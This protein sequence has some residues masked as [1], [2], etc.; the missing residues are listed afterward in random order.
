MAVLLL[1]ISLVFFVLLIM[2]YT[3]SGLL[4]AMI[5]SALLFVMLILVITEGLS[6]FQMLDRSTLVLTWMIILILQ[7]FLIYKGRAHLPGV[8]ESL[9]RTWNSGRKIIFQSSDRRYRWLLALV[10]LILLFIVLQSLLYPPNNWDSMTYHMARIPH[11]L[12]Q[13]AASH[14]PTH[15][16]RQLYQPPLAE[17][18]ILQLTVL[19]GSDIYANLLQFTFYLMSA[20]VLLA[21]LKEFKLSLQVRFCAAL[22]LL[23][24]PEAIL[25]ASSTQNDIVVS[26][27]ILSSL[28]YLLRFRG[29]KGR[30]ADLLFLGISARTSCID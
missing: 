18:M 22:L 15:I 2:V 21:L 29:E 8:K 6:L 19:A 13:G 10:F 17:Y 24:L 1:D 28:Y 9:L 26:F 12:S 7:S 20:V 25:Q 5:K 3:E 16:L 23:S 27:F 11:W 14:Y 4:E 30:G